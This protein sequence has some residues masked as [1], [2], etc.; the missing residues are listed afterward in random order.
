MQ[1]CPYDAIY[2]NED[3]G[4]VE[5]CHFCAHRVEVGL[6]PACVIVCPVEA[7]IPGDFDDPGSKVSPDRARARHGPGSAARA[8]HG[9]QRALPRRRRS[10]PA[11]GSR[12][13]TGDVHLER[14]A[15][16]RSPSHGPRRFPS[17]RTP[18][19]C[20]TPGTSRMGLAGRRLPGDQGDRG[21]RCHP[22]AVRVGARSARARRRDF[23]ARDRC[24]AS[25]PRRP[26]SSSSRT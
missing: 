10:R 18:G 24:P 6:E 14:S 26:A 1:A 22:G 3:S 21:R 16:A 5:K 12:S 2:L 8:G 11:A 7:I 17:S 20:S 25:S 23:A 9:P 4:A 19:W 15:A 13:A